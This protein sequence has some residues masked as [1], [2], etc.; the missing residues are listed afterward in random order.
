MKM[1]NFASWYQSGTWNFAS[2]SQFGAKGPAAATFST[3]ATFA[4]TAELS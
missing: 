4:R 1:P 2:D 3:S